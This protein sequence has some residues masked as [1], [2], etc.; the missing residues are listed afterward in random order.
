M[1]PA[2]KYVER[3]REIESHH[4]PQ[5]SW[6]QAEIARALEQAA[7]EGKIEAVG[8]VSETSLKQWRARLAELEGKD[9]KEIK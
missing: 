6:R 4:T 7:L 8:C 2:D 5:S 1:I 3:A 9:V